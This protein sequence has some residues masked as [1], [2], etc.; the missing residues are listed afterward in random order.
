MS[1]NLVP[2]GTFTMG[3]PDGSGSEPAE[4]G[5]YPEETQHEV[6]LSQSFYMQTTEV[7]NKQWNDII[8]VP[9]LGVNPSQSHTGDNYPVEYV[10]WYEAAYFA[11]R[12]SVVEGRSQ[13]YTLNGCNANAPG[14]GMECSSVEI[15]DTC[16]GYR[17]PTEAQWEYAARATT[18]T[19][20]ANPVYS[21]TTNSETGSG[22]NTNLHAMGWYY[23]NNAMVNSSAVPAYASGT[24]PVAAKQANYWGLYDMHGNVYEWCQDW[25]D[26]TAYSSDPVTDP[27]G[28]ASGA[29]R[30]YRGGF[31]YGYAR[32]SRSAYRSGDFPGYRGYYLGF[33]LALP[34]GQ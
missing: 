19:A 13:C 24:K 9:T 3:S 5:R 26:F 6:T 16:T 18:T 31:W 29:Y 22:F 12:L 20:Y 14:A 10:N 28:D 15:S 21:D 17:L 11:N 4:P 32:S 33:R 23:Y 27:Q 7:T 30:V 1:F 2:A 8:V 34:P 25:W